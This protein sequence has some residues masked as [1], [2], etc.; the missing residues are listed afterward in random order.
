MV[1]PKIMETRVNTYMHVQEGNNN[2]TR[3]L[4]RAISYTMGLRML[5]PSH[6]YMY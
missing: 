3:N 4:L 5:L 1:V 2:N 6:A